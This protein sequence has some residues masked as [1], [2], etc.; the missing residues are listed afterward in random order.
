M[1]SIAADAPLGKRRTLRKKA[2]ARV[3]RIAFGIE[4]GTNDSVDVIVRS[5]L[6]D[7]MRLEISGHGV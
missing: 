1:R 6:H 3:D 4:R 7:L 5:H 2:V